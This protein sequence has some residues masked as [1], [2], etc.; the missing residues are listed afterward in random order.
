[1]LV[2]LRHPSVPGK[3]VLTYAL[4][5]D[6]SNAVLV[7][8]S[9]FERLGIEA[10]PTNIKVSTVLNKD[11]LIASHRVRNLEVS[12]YH[13]QKSILLP[14]AYTRDDLPA[15]DSDIPTRRAASQWDHLK[16]IANR[17]PEQRKVEIGLLIGRNVPQAMKTREVVNGKDDEPWAERYETY[18]KTLRKTT[19]MRRSKSTEL[20]YATVQRQKKCTRHRMFSE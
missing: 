12:D 2:W 11:Q 4:L 8:E 9:V 19:A 14:T 15:D 13:H 16:H 5:D 18:A 1:M 10:S 20:L 3:E 17:I 7:K 6:Q